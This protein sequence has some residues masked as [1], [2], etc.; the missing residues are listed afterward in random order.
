MADKI[1]QT[2]N[3]YIGFTDSEDKLKTIKIPNP[4][5][6]A[7]TEESI[8]SA[9]EALIGIGITDSMDE[10]F[11][12]TSITTAYVEQVSKTELDI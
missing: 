5:S 11:S 12:S 1:T 4:D 2:N 6:D 7:T 9:A 8:R 10:P 3:L